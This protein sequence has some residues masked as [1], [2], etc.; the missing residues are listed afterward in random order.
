MLNWFGPDRQL[1]KLIN[2]VVLELT[3]LGLSPSVLHSL[4]QPKDAESSRSIKGKER[5]AGE[6]PF[7]SSEGEDT[8]D[9]STSSPNELQE[10]RSAETPQ[11]KAVY[12]LVQDGERLEPRLRLWV[13]ETRDHFDEEIIT[14]D[15][16]ELDSRV[17]IYLDNPDSAPS[18]PIVERSESGPGRSKSHEDLLLVSKPV[19]SNPGQSLVWSL[20]RPPRHGDA[21]QESSEEVW[22][23]LGSKMDVEEI[24]PH[25][26]ELVKRQYAIVHLYDQEFYLLHIVFI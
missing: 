26:V 11:P 22:K 6:R 10:Q 14:A 7:E 15:E 25:P 20:Q 18:S 13:G 21:E 17:A 24:A 1:K 5:A 2:K 4:L 3:S 8:D 19:T 16:D 23:S 12:E 9:P